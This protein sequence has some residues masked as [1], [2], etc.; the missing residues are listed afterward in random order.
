M[1]RWV[2]CLPAKLAVRVRISL[3]GEIFSIVNGAPMHATFHYK[4][5]KMYAIHPYVN[6]CLLMDFH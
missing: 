6:G 3:D 1:A 2:K 4:N 5:V